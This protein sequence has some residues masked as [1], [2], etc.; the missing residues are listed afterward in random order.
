MNKDK[1]SI[2]NIIVFITDAL[3][4]VISYYLAGMIWLGLYKGGSAERVIR[5]LN[6]NILTII[7]AMLITVLFYNIKQDFISRGKAA[8]LYSVIL[9]CAILSAVVAVYELLRKSPDIISR[10]VYVVTF[11]AGIFL[12][13]ITRLIVKKYLVYWNSKDKAL[14][15]LMITLKDRAVLTLEKVNEKD[16]WFRRLEG[17]IIMDEDMVGQKIQGVP[18]VANSNTLMHYIKNEVVD[19]VYIDTTYAIR[20]KI[21][22]MVMDLE[23]MG[24]TVHL[25]IEMLESYKD[26]DARMGYMGN[27]PVIT[28]SNRI[29][30]WHE[31]WLKGIMDMLGALVGLLVM[32]I[33][34]I[35]IAPAIKIES[36]GP[37]FF[38]QQRVG[39]NGRIFYIYKFRSMY[40]DAEE[41]KKE[42]MAQNEM[43]GLMFKMKDDPRITKVGKFIR[44]TSIDELPQ[45]INVF[46]GDMSLVGTRPPTV[47][48]FKQ[49]KGH[50]KRRLSMKPGIT[51]MW[52]AYGRNTVSDFEEVV[53]MDLD[54]I[55]HWSLALD[56][57]I[58]LK[59]I[60]TVFTDGG[61]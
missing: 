22:P 40:V 16:D 24:V 58:L 11:I 42:L 18:V 28:F 5:T 50:H 19:E 20:E 15:V 43:N 13:F 35:F 59:T 6:N 30:S 37:L 17:I 21:K 36:K 48:E 1:E 53:K 52:Q 57:K 4:I 32:L 45:F 44:K 61:K 54:Y 39:K 55:D 2:Q 31:M 49:Y 26:F 25:K 14:R 38:R 29:Y 12:M 33:V 51:G 46:L 47:D 10:G 3:S 34:M 27:I 56:V 23:D 9:K 41:R 60:V 7:M 8:E